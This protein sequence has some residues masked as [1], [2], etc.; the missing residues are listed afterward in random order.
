[1]RIAI[2][3]QRIFRT[4]KHGMDFVVLEMIR[5]LQ[6]IDR[7]NE[8][9]IFVAPGDDVC[10]SETPNFHIVCLNSSFYPFWEQVLL[11]RAV[12]RIKAD[13]LHCTSNTA[14]LFPG[15][16]LILTLHDVIALEKLT[17]RN[18]STYQN[19]GRVYSRFVVPKVLKKCTKVITVSHYEKER[20]LEK[21]GISGDKVTVIYNGFG[22]EFNSS[23]SSDDRS[24]IL[25][26]GA[27]TP[28]KNMKG[29]LMAYSRYLEKSERKLP[30][31]IADC[32]RSLMMSM[33]GEIGCLQAAEHIQCPG[34]I[35]HSALPGTYG[36]AVAFLYTSLRES[37]GIPQLEA[38]ACCT[39]VIVSN[40]SALPEIAGE[41]AL[42]VDP[43]DPDAISDLL[44]RIE[45][46]GEFRKASIEY[47]LER[48]EKFSWELTA[49]KALSTYESEYLCLSRKI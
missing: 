11:P 35:P 17:D 40:S 46:D 25:F 29:T 37:F 14:P 22:K 5:C 7:K 49:E 23:A 18:S 30:L 33:L 6:E 42:L 27:P 47:G 34:Y 31:L 43:L 38:M 26:F 41:G 4:K 48:I 24:Y 39:P 9:W 19:L 16:P 1:M 10:L 15:V 13:I 12:K 3:A 32:D 8:Y 28:K 36:H 44:V 20:I 45:S 2:E 21:T